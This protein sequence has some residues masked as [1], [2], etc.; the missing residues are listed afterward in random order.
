VKAEPKARL[1]PKI[2]PDDPEARDEGPRLIPLTETPA[3][4]DISM[5]S[6]YLDLADYAINGPKKKR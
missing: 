2:R 3:H 1:I 5:H 6:R 4:S